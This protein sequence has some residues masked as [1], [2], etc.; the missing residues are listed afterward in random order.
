MLT[1]FVVTADK[2]AADIFF[3]SADKKKQLRTGIKNAHYCL[4]PDG[5]VQSYRHKKISLLLISAKDQTEI[6]FIH[7]TNSYFLDLV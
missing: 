1:V 4:N 5:I 6:I 7:F 2:K 3:C